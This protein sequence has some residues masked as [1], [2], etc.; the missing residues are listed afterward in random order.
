M[1]LGI[2]KMVTFDPARFVDQ[3]AQR[4]AKTPRVPVRTKAK[5]KSVAIDHMTKLEQDPDRV[6]S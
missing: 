5:L 3:D 4:F 6:M 1:G 2:E